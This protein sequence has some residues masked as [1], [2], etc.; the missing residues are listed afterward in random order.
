MTTSVLTLLNVTCGQVLPAEEDGRARRIQLIVLAAL[1]SLGLAALWGLA[2]G[3]A[4]FTLALG[5]LYKVPMVVLLSAVS[6]VPA[7]MLTWKLMGVR[8]SGTDLLMGFATG[9]FSGTLVLGV[10]APL[11]AIYYHTSA[12]AGPVLGM[13]SV[14]MSLLVATVVF[15]RNV[16]KRVPEGTSKKA[17]LLPVAVFLFMQVATLIQFIALAS[18]ILPELTVFDGGVDHMIGR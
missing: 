3:S 10:L 16:L 2:A 8:Y 4:S 14:F 1:A 11:V 6:A 7:G 17:L 13:G 15:L 9:V 18:P 5:N 12:W